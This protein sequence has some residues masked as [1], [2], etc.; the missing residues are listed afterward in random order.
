MDQLV[1]M[2]AARSVTRQYIALGGKA[3]Q[4]AKNRLVEFPI[5]RDVRNRLRMAVVDLAKHSGKA[6]ATEVTLIKSAA[7]HCLVRCKLRTG[8]THQIRVHMATLGHPLVSDVLYGGVMAGGLQRQALHAWRL[9]FEH[10]ATHV[11]MIFKAAIPTDMQNAMAD[12]D[13]TYNEGD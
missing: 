2:I 5:G 8:R 12:L 1:D 4:G 11:P 6:A 10:P 9:A 7:A 13:L 3:W